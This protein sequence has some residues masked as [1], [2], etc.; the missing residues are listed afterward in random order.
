MLFR[1]LRTV[2]GHDDWVS[3]V[4]F[5]PDGLTLASAGYDNT[6]R[7]WHAASGDEHWRVVMAAPGHATFDLVN[8]RLIEAGGDAWRYLFDLTVDADGR[9]DVLPWETYGALPV[10]QLLPSRSGTEPPT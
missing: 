6:L 3:S 1:S 5:A 9:P 10:P 2:Q 7:L 8:N 4:A